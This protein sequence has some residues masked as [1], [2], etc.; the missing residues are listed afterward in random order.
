MLSAREPHDRLFID[1]MVFQRDFYAVSANLRF[2]SVSI[3]M[4]L[5]QRGFLI[6]VAMLIVL[7]V[8]L[9]LWKISRPV[10]VSA[11]TQAN[12]D[13]VAGLRV[14]RERLQ[15]ILDGACESVELR[16]LRQRN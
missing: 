10:L 12:L 9:H 7:N 16:V 5:T 15:A 14:E 2:S 8:C 3:H 11:S 1:P 13:L 4:K 6:A